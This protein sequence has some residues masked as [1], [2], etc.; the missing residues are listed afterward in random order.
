MTSLSSLVYDCIRAECLLTSF[1]IPRLAPDTRPVTRT[2]WAELFD[3]IFR[4]PTHRDRDKERGQHCHKTSLK[5]GRTIFCRHFN[6]YLN[7]RTQSFKNIL[8]TN[9][10]ITNWPLRL[11]VVFESK[12]FFVPEWVL[13]Q[14]LFFSLPWVLFY[15]KHTILCWPGTLICQNLNRNW[16]QMSKCKWSNKLKHTFLFSQDPDWEFLISPCCLR[17]QERPRWP[18]VIDTP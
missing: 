14:F 7:C 9:W 18:G 12:A 17:F 6:L 8:K 2:A 16:P 1:I 13:T 10:N 4:K 11:K 5:H 15:R 3:L